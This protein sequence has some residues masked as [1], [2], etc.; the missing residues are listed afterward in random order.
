M[1]KISI[2]NLTKI[3]GSH[4]G[5]ALGMLERGMTKKEI[6]KKT[7][8][9]VGVNRASFS[10]QSGEVF[11]IMG[12][13][14]SGKSTL[15]R[16]INRLIEPTAGSVMVD[17]ENVT[18]MNPGQLR[19]LRRKTISMVFQGFGL[20]PHRT[21]L[22]NVEYGLEVQGISKEKRR[23]K[24]LE[25]LDLVGLKQNA[26]QMPGDLSGGMK[27]RVGLA[28]ALANDPEILLMDEAFSALD[29][30]IR[31]D[32]QDEMLDL[33][34]T[35]KKTIVFITHDLDEALRIGDRIALIRDGTIQ[36]VGTPEEILTHPANQY[37][38]K[39][40]ENVNVNRILPA[41][42]IMKRAE[43]MILGKDGPR[44]AL[45]MMRDKGTSGL[46]VVDRRNKFLGFI[47][48]DI[49]KELITRHKEGQSVAEEIQNRLIKP[50]IQVEMDT[51]VSDI[52][53][54]MAEKDFQYPAAVVDSEGRL[55]GVIVRGAIFAVLAGKNGG[56]DNDDN[57]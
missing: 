48:A 16:L 54:K 14:G 20:F 2:N 12:L 41:S 35:M 1:E 27:Q 47:T 44:V 31:K 56:A 18:K 23:K 45:K 8:M 49:A 37:V 26:N 29:P 40:I 15:I 4:P 55:K 10:V 3:F 50:P 6:F 33:Q 7:G 25:T 24:A 51:P 46:M 32:M 11:V 53:P 38:E 28:R 5:R 17:G 30:L 42:S 22:E 9:T 43:K 57:A 13:S 34:S 21:V 19:E 36:Q 39:F 52:L